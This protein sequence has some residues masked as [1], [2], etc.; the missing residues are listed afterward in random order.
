MSS[1]VKPCVNIFLQLN[2]ELIL[3]SFFDTRNYET[4]FNDLVAF[5]SSPNCACKTQVKTSGDG[6]GCNG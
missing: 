1:R 6:F 4:R 2:C 5:Q 3:F